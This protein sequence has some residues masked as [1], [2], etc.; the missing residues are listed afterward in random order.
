MT[1]AAELAAIAE[2]VLS[3]LGEPTVS[4]LIW[5]LANQGVSTAPGEFDIHKFDEE[6][7]RIFG[8]GASVFME[9]IYAQFKSM[10]QT[11]SD[12]LFVQDDETLSP[13]DKIKRILAVR[14]PS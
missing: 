12:P 2:S 9:E 13:I 8:D 1:V 10:C 5:E 11:E 6:M 14:V 3:S 4:A 7:R